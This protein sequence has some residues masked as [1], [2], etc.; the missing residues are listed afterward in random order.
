MRPAG[1]KRAWP[2]AALRPGLRWAIEAPSS[3]APG[4]V[5]AL[6][7]LGGRIRGQFSANGMSTINGV[8][9]VARVRRLQNQLPGLVMGEGILETRF[10]GHQPIGLRAQGSER[11]RYLRHTGNAYSGRADLAQGTR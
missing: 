5:A 3:A 1:L 7:K 2:G 6:G 4:V 10:G 9:P 8:L 11:V